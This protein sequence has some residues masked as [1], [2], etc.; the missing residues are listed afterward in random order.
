M[1][2]DGEQHKTNSKT[3]PLLDS[4]N[5]KNW[6][7]GIL[8]ATWLLTTVFSFWWFQFKNIQSF[9]L[10]AQ[11]NQTVFFE[12]GELGERLENLVNNT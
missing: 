5:K 3:L 11:K 8:V 6:F 2:L 9:D 12:S 10:D 4:T 1:K 7:V